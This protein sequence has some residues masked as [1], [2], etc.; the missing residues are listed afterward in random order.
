V[1]HPK[2]VANIVNVNYVKTTKIIIGSDRCRRR[3]RKDLQDKLRDFEPWRGNAEMHV[4]LLVVAVLIFKNM[5]VVDD[6]NWLVCLVDDF[7]GVGGVSGPTAP[8]A[9]ATA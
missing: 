1:P 5:T 8:G 2:V 9:S 3:R 4:T 6:A 7:K